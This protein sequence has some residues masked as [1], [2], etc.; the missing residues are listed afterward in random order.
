MLK[1]IIKQLA[2]EQKALKKTRKTG[3]L[4]IE[5][6]AYGY[7]ILTEAMC[8]S[9]AA[10]SKVQS[11]KIIITAALNLYH[12]LRGSDYR[13][14]YCPGHKWSYDQAIKNLTKQLADAPRI[15]EAN[16]PKTN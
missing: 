14:S 2:E 3:T 1:E 8:Q 6:N 4:N 5:R 9:Y 10:N 13:H 11:N 15:L 12:E 16:P 7:A